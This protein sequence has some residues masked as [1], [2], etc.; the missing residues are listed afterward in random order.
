MSEPRGLLHRLLD[1][2][3]EQAKDVDPR[4]FRLSAV[5]GL[6]W[7][8]SDIAGLPGIETDLK[9][10]ADHFWVRVPRLRV[11]TPGAVS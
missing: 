10:A 3:A 6:I 7:R 2:I 5:K 11:P 9:G 8:P 1:Y 4:G